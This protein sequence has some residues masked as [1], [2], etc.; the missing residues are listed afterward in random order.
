MRFTDIE[1]NIIFASTDM[2][3]VNKDRLDRNSAKKKRSH[4][5]ETGKGFGLWGSDGVYKNYLVSKRKI[6]CTMI[7]S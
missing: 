4:Y 3:G 1:R 7:P 2:R 6:E 5:R